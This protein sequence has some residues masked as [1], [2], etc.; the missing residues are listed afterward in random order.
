MKRAFGIRVVPCRF[1]QDNRD[2]FLDHSA[3]TISDALTSV[4]HIGKRVAQALYRMR[5]ETYACFT[6]L[7]YEMTMNPA[8]DSRAI[9]I[10][11]RLDYFREFGTPGKL[12][13]VFRQF[14]AGEFRFSKTYVAA[15]QEKRLAALRVQEQNM[16]EEK[17]PLAECLRFEAE[18]MGTPLTVRESERAV[19]VVLEVDDRYTPKLRM[20]SVATG[21]VGIMKLKKA[22]FQAQP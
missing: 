16:P 13:G 5:N 4:K 11:I 14:Q 21:N 18:H 8:F 10:L 17:L 7:L 22:S 3:N 12:L 6:D 9:E 20:Y 1:R 19:Y 2:Y 15:T